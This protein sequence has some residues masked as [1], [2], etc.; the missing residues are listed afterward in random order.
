MANDQAATD[1]SSAK[2]LQPVP[3]DP[4]GRLDISSPKFRT[5]DPGTWGYAAAPRLIFGLGV[6]NGR[7][8]YAVARDLQI[9]SGAIAP[10][11]GAD[12]RLEL[13]V[14]PGPGPTLGLLGAPA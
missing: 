3:Y 1:L 14:A 8:Y 7:L 12:P 6:R 13:S 11:F 4:A 10:Q 5:G 9:W 2:G